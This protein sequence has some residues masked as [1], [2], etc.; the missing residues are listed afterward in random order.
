MKKQFVMNS[1][2][3]SMNVSIHSLNDI[4]SI[5]HMLIDLSK[6]CELVKKVGGRVNRDDRN[7][8]FRAI[9]D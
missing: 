4:F 8:R 6:R 1:V 7:K 9:Q 5:K 3:V 2:V